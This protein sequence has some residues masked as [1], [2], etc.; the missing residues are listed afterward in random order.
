MSLNRTNSIHSTKARAD[1]ARTATEMPT[2]A[3]R[4][5]RMRRF[6]P[7]FWPTLAAAVLVPIFLAAGQ[8]QWNKAS[9]KADLQARLD[10]GGAEPSLMLPATLVDAQELRF[11]R[12]VAYGHY[13]PQHQILIDNRIYHGQGGYH[14][15]TPLR[16]EGSET[17]VLIN[18]GWVPALADH[19]DVP[20]LSTPEG[21]IELSGTAIVPGTRFFTLAADTD[22]G[23]SQWQR[24]WQNLD[25]DRYRKAVS[26]PIQPIV[27]QLDPESTAGG[28]VR[29]WPRSDE[30]IQTNLSYAVQWWTF[31][32]TTVVLWLI[33]NIRRTA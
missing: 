22:D 25:L 2:T 11:R 26:F 5:Q 10:A 7:R 4:R 14:V 19:R 18:R 32:A 31:A 21:R 30:R 6:Q 20:L 17:R 8:W 3:P 28:F 9:A 12:V 33:F 27:I 16:L 29:E 13:E 23:S 24:V 1:Y 15:M